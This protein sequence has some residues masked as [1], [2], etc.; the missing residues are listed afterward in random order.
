[1]QQI[2]ELG[3]SARSAAN[4]K[5]SREMQ[6]VSAAPRI[7]SGIAR[8]VPAGGFRPRRLD[9]TV[10]F[11]VEIAIFLKNALAPCSSSALVE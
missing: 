1:M 5:T 9:A 6:G 3:G 4:A 7:K 2:G 8:G 10:R 11:R